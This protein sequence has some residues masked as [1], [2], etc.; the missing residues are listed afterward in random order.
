MKTYVFDRFDYV[1]DF[2]HLPQGTIL[3]RGIQ[4]NIPESGVLR[5]M[6]MYL[7]PESIAR[8]YGKVYALETIKGVRLL[9]LRKIISLLPTILS[10]MQKFGNDE[11]NCA[12]HLSMAYGCCSYRTQIE[13][14]SSYYQHISPRI[15]ADINNKFKKRI[16]NMI[17][18]DFNKVPHDPIEIKGIRTGDSNINGYAVS[19]FK[20]IFKHWCDGYIAP[21]MF[22][23]YQEEGWVHEEIVIFRPK[24]FLKLS[25]ATNP[26]RVN[27]NE[28]LSDYRPIEIKGH[29]MAT[30][31]MKGGSLLQ[32]DRNLFFDDVN[33]AKDASKKAKKF[34]KQF[35]K[36]GFPMCVSPLEHLSEKE[37][38]DITKSIDW[39][40]PMNKL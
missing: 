17:S 11:L 8:V 40:P 19:V 1:D 37:I 38:D 6:P 27:I 21:R 15:P 14:L 9:D 30:K 26:T 35:K 39:G 7:A 28:L 2:V 22:S 25:S 12:A 16:H 4:D 10:S 32:E 3:Y 24:E 23:P 36:R 29:T 5:D 33:M 31:I 34:A 20:E 13:K 18:F